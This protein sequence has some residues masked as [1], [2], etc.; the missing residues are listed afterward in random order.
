MLNIIVEKE[1]TSILEL[2]QTGWKHTRH[3]F[4]HD[5]SG[6][7]AFVVFQVPHGPGRGGELAQARHRHGCAG[8]EPGDARA[9]AA[10]EDGAG[11]GQPPRGGRV[12]QRRATSESDHPLRQARGSAHVSVFCSS[13]RAAPLLL[14]K[15]F[16]DASAALPPKKI[17][18]CFAG[19]FER[20]YGPADPTRPA[21]VQRPVLGV[22]LL[23]LHQ[24]RGKLAF[25]LAL[26][27][28]P[29]VLSVSLSISISV[30]DV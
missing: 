20:F 9:A 30:A 15:H 21:L 2:L 13:C 12:A 8:A 10:H 3:V 27:L 17:D 24:R 4:E 11:A 1:N 16:H 23:R 6:V 28:P 25:A 22:W 5:P 29:V 14:K 7:L 18:A 26:S 19:A